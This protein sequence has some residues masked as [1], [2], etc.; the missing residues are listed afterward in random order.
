VVSQSG[1]QGGEG[2]AEG[3]MQDELSLCERCVCVWGHG[4]RSE[5]EWHLSPQ[6]SVL[7]ALSH[8]KALAPPHLRRPTCMF[9]WW[10]WAW[11]TVVWSGQEKPDLHLATSQPPTAAQKYPWSQTTLVWQGLP[12]ETASE[13]RL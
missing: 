3:R 11:D 4:S 1:C 10:T 2:R 13:S 12:L 9:L 6:D 5:T 7:K 8:F